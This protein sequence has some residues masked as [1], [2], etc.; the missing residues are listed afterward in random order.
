MK[1]DMKYHTQIGIYNKL[2]RYS[3]IDSESDIQLL[4]T[5]YFSDSSMNR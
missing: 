2:V 5:I 4:C 3:A 1:T